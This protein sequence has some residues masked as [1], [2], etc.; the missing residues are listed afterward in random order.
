VRRQLKDIRQQVD[1]LSDD[2]KTVFA[3]TF[4]QISRSEDEVSKVL[5]ELFNKPT[6]HTFEEL[7]RARERKERGNPPGKKGDPMGDQLIWEQFLSHFRAGSRVWIISRDPDYGTTYGKSMSLN[8]FLYDE[9]ARKN[10]KP[11]EVYCFDSLTKG[12]PDFVKKTLVQAKK[13]PKEEELAKIQKEVDSLPL[14]G[15][16]SWMTYS[17]PVTSTVGVMSSSQ[18]VTLTWDPRT[19]AVYTVTSGGAGDIPLTLRKEAEKEAEKPSEP[20]TE[21]SDEPK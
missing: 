17:G 13:L 7:Q 11:P 15:D 12:L 8:P 4:G 14:R 3:R 10:G 19:G 18:N 20:K 5:T 9:L 1:T 6:E 21:E 16:L 2:L